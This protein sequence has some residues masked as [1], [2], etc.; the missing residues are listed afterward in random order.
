MARLRNVPSPPFRAKP[1][2][3]MPGVKRLT[4]G[5][6]A[7]SF[8][9]IGVLIWYARQV[10][11]PPLPVT[12]QFLSDIH[13]SGFVLIFRNESDRPLSFTAA[14]KHPGQQEGMSF[15]IQVQ[16]RGTYELQGSQWLGESGDRITLT[17]PHYRVWT[18]GLP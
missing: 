14:L 13:G 12:V 9:L 10:L 11:E 16:A 1:I 5:K 15:P 17:G 4:P 18:G 3:R 2:R 6:L 7:A 8:I